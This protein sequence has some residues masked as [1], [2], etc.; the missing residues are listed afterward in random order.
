MAILSANIRGLT[1]SVGKFKIKML[2]EKAVDENIAVITLTK[3]H[4]TSDFLEG[5]ISMKGFVN[6]RADRKAGTRKGGIITYVRHDLLPGLEI[7]KA[8]SSGNIEYLIIKLQVA[9]PP[10]SQW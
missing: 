10:V 5:E 2:Q 7:L 9:E 6:F 1:P 8:G 3:S 4:L